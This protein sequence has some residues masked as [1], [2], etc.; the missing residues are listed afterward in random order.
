MVKLGCEE[1]RGLRRF[2]KAGWV[3]SGGGQGTGIEEQREAGSCCG[4]YIAEEVG[5]GALLVLDR[6]GD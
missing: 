6:V 1:R 3:N 2:Y 4:D 5:R